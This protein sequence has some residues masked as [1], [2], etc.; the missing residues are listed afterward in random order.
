MV[1]NVTGSLLA[2]ILGAVSGAV[3]ANE[4]YIGGR[5][6]GKRGRGAANKTPVVTLVERGG[7]ALSQV[8][9]NVTGANI[10]KV[11]QEQVQADAVLMTD[12]LN[13]YVSAG[14][15]F[16]AHETVDHGKDEY[17]KDTTHGRAPSTRRKGASRS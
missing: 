13:V 12:T 4:T 10:K 14:K 7:Q 8:V 5:A 16:A 11:L 9:T 3:E 2:H 15:E 1:C 6:H 17:A